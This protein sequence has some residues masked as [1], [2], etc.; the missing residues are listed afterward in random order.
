MPRT[1]VLDNLITDYREKLIHHQPGYKII[2][3]V[4]QLIYDP[5]T[6]KLKILYKGDRYTK[7]ETEGWEN[8]EGIEFKHHQ[9][10][11]LPLT[12]LNI[13]SS[14]VITILMGHLMPRTF[15]VAVEYDTREDRNIAIVGVGDY[16]LWKRS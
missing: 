11:E 1:N 2:I 5:G 13:P 14:G 10:A 8:V 6:K 3:E 4:R 7:M 16:R 9:Y 12:Y 15:D